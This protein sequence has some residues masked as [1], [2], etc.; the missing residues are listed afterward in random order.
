MRWSL[1]LS[2]LDFVVE[3]RPGAK[4][5]HAD[6]LSRHVAAIEQGEPLSRKNILEQQRPDEFCK[7][8]VTGNGP[9][10]SEYTG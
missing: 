2:E 7:R 5:P 8:Q 4:I 1:K 9:G 3:H 6:A 10:K